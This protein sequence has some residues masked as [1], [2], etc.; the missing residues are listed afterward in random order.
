MGDRIWI[1]QK[2]SEAYEVSL[3]QSDMR[4]CQRRLVMVT[5]YVLVLI[6]F[7]DS[8]HFWYGAAPVTSQS[9]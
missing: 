4:L 9:G 7:D 1:T 5:E 8:F 2:Q 6:H 3:P